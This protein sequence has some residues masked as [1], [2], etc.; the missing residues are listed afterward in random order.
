MNLGS[1]FITS[2]AVLGLHLAVL[3]LMV[4]IEVPK[5]M[6]LIPVGGSA[7]EVLSLLGV[8]MGKGRMD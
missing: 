8:K 3:Y 7:Y 2:T 6:L 1:R 4:E 5:L